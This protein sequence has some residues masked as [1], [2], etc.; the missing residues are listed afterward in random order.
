MAQNGLEV[1]LFEYR[2]GK[3]IIERVVLPKMFWPINYSLALDLNEE[4]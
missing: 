3:K 2:K 1:H 4:I